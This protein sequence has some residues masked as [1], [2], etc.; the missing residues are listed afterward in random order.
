MSNYLSNYTEVDFIFHNLDK[1]E[2]L[3]DRYQ[4]DQGT[5]LSIVL[6]VEHLYLNV[7]NLNTNNARTRVNLNEDHI[8]EKPLMRSFT[9]YNHL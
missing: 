1:P 7:F 8:D 2:V 9:N 5:G 3:E 6:Y 4:F